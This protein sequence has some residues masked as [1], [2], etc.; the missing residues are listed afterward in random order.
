[1]YEI[2]PI[3]ISLSGTLHEH[4]DEVTSLVITIPN[5]NKQP[6]FKYLQDSVAEPPPPLGTPLGEGEGRDVMLG[7][8]PRIF[9]PFLVLNLFSRLSGSKLNRPQ[10]G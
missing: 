5:R 8:L 10:G 7:N 2:P 3:N 4:P 6:P 9:C 1:M